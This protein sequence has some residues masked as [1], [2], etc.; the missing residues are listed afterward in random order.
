MLGGQ[1]RNSAKKNRIH[2]RTF[3]FERSV[4]VYVSTD[5]VLH[6]HM[7]DYLAAAADPQC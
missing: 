3:L 6:A 7:A 5:K 2:I 1:D 4:G